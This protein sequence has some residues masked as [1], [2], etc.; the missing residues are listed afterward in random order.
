MIALVKYENNCFHMTSILLFSDDDMTR[1]LVTPIGFFSCSVRENNG[2]YINCSCTEKV[3][4]V[5]GG[6]SGLRKWRASGERIGLKVS[7]RRAGGTGMRSDGL[8]D[9]LG[10]KKQCPAHL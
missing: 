6:R 2:V 4:L 7:M 5:R 9:G 1:S 8:R 10:K 3:Y